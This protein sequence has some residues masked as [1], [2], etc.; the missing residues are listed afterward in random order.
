MTGQPSRR[1]TTWDGTER[2]STSGNA[3]WDGCDTPP[4]TRHTR[5]KPGVK[6]PDSTQP[7]CPSQVAVEAGQSRDQNDDYGI[8]VHLPAELPVLNKCASR[9]LLA[10]LVRL[11][12]VEALDAPMEGDGV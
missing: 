4:P 2:T 1:H 8:T 10:I 3:G 5:P 9:I 11:T 12:E 7:P 6:R